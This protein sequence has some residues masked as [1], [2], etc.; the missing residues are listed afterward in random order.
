[1]HAS[2][3]AKVVVYS[4]KT[5]RDRGTEGRGCSDETRPAGISPQVLKAG[6]RVKIIAHPPRDKS[7]RTA[8]FMGVGVN[9]WYYSLSTGSNIRGKED[10]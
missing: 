4:S 9:G 6:N 7:Q 1:M 10:N 5:L 3:F 2:R 8:E